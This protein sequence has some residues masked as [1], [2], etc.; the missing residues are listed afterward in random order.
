[1]HQLIVNQP[2]VYSMIERPLVLS[3]LSILS[4]IYQPGCRVPGLYQSHLFLGAFY[5]D[6]GTPLLFQICPNFLIPV[7]YS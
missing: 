6:P 2:T 5:A 4:K 1:M 7:K 3:Y